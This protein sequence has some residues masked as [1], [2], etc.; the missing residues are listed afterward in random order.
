MAL[1]GKHIYKPNHVNIKHIIQTILNFPFYPCSTRVSNELG[2]GNPRVAKLAVH[3]V[4]CI[5]IAESI[6]IGLILILIRNLWGMAYSSE[7]EVVT[8]IASMMPILALGN[9]IDSIQ[10]VLS[11]LFYFFGLK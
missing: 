1:Q 6:V 3:V 7:P 11:G 9:F 8:Y 2:A 5:A 10:C 4:I